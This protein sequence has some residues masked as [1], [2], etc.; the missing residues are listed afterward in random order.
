MRLRR[1]QKQEERVRTD[2]RDFTRYEVIVDGHQRPPQNKRRA[3]LDMVHQLIERDVPASA[4]KGVLGGRFRSVE[5]DIEDG[6]AVAVALRS[7]QPWTQAGRVVC[8]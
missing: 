4:I 6:D 2:N 5:G 3:V 8:G 1:K 7:C